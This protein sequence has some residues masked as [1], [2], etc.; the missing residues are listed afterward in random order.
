MARRSTPE[1]L[2]IAHRSGTLERIV[3]AGVPRDRA[4]AAL[5]AWEARMAREGRRR[6]DWPWDAAFREIAAP[7]RSQ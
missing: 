4:E 6:D 7:P 5:A 3:S 1:R 2:Y